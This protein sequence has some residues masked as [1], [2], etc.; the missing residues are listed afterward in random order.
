MSLE[1]KLLSETRQQR[2]TRERQ[3]AEERSQETL[4]KLSVRC[5]GRTDFL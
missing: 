1:D 2:K 3:A 4:H 5:I